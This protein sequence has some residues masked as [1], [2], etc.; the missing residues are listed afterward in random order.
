MPDGRIGL[1]DYG[2]VKRI[3]SEDRRKYARLV[4]VK[5]MLE[6]K[7]GMLVIYLDTTQALAERNEAEVVRTA[8]EELGLRTRHMNA[9]IIYKVSIL[10]LVS[11]VISPRLNSYSSTA[12][13]GT[14]EIR[15]I[16]L[17]D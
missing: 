4:K 11:M 17:E 12:R 3:C 14:I 16:L 2:Q 5:P 13:S 6:V 10:S 9:D 8:V 1:I 15:K 7:T